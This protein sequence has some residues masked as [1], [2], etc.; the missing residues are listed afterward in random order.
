MPLAPL[1]F[2]R[3]IN[4][5]PSRRA[6]SGRPLIMVPRNFPPSHYPDLDDKTAKQLMVPITILSLTFSHHLEVGKKL[7]YIGILIIIRRTR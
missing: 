1:I 4:P 2:G 7:S 5:I 6:D 3:S